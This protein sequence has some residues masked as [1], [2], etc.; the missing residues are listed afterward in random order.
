MTSRHEKIELRV[1]AFM[2]ALVA[3]V[4]SALVY[5]G[6]KKDLFAD[7]LS[8]YVISTTGENVERGTPVRLSGFRI[9]QVDDVDLSQ[10]GQVIIEMQILEKYHDWLRADSQIILVQGGFIGKTYL[11]LVPGSQDQPMLEENTRIKLH[12]VGGLDEILAE[13]RP[14]IDD[15]KEIVANINDITTQLLDE[16]GPAQT[17]LANLRDMSRDLRSDE[18]L[19]GYL[20]R[21]P[22][23]VQK[24]DSLLTEGDR[25]MH[26]VRGLSDAAKDRVQDLAPLQEEAVKLVQEVNG[27]VKELKAFREDLR[28]AV[29]NAVTITENVRDASKDLDRL[30]ARTE[31][32]IRLGTELLQRLNATWPLSRGG[33]PAPPTEHPLP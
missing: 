19:V 32:T 17:I 14:V 12:R 20:T 13:A 27:F 22:E 1:G 11:K 4:V 18:G 23:P 3:L 29:E 31:Y 5:V 24:I 30:R 8:F 9:G 25:L 33:E 15:L 10:V 21:S 28:P 26:S 6:V 7:R 2:L 16:K